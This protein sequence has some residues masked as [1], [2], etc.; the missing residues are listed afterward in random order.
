[1]WES[2]NKG[3]ETISKQRRSK[4]HQSK[5]RANEAAKT[6]TAKSGKENRF[7]STNGV[8][9]PTDPIQ[10]K[11]KEMGAREDNTNNQKRIEQSFRWGNERGDYPIL[12]KFIPPQA[13]LILQLAHRHT[14]KTR[15]GSSSC[16]G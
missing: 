8:Q 16:F 13:L 14:Q 6:K 1:M 4:A 11:E 12:S 5:E 2:Q 15:T 10:K 3:S 7:D 9:W